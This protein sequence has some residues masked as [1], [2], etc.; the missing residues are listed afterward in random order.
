[1]FDA[2]INGTDAEHPNEI[3]KISLM[4]VISNFRIQ[5]VNEELLPVIFM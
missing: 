2:L 1:M 3:T 5:G 4:S